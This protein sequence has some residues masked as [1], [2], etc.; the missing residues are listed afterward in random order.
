MDRGFGVIAFGLI[1]AALCSAQSNPARNEVAPGWV[2]ESG[3]D[4]PLGLVGG[5]L[6]H[7]ARGIH[8]PIA[9]DPQTEGGRWWPLHEGARGA[10]I[11]RRAPGGCVALT[12][13]TDL[14]ILSRKPLPFG[15]D[16]ESVRFFGTEPAWRESRFDLGCA[17]ESFCLSPCL[18]F[19]AFC[20]FEQSAIKIKNLDSGA[21][22]DLK[23]DFEGR[24]S[25]APD[26]TTLA[27]VSC[28]QGVAFFPDPAAGPSKNEVFLTLPPRDYGSVRFGEPRWEHANALNVRLRIGSGV[29]V[30]AVGTLHI[31]PRAFRGGPARIDLG[32]VLSKKSLA[33]V[34]FTPDSPKEQTAIEQH[35][36]TGIRFSAPIVP[37]ARSFSADSRSFSADSR[38]FSADSRS[39]SG[40][41]YLHQVYDTPDWFDG[42]WAC[43]PTSCVM[44]VQKWKRLPYWLCRC[45]YP[46]SH[47]S[48][49]GPLIAGQFENNGTNFNW[50]SYDASG[51]PARGA[52]G[53][54]CPGGSAYWSRMNDFMQW[55]GCTTY[56]DSSP[57]WS[58]L[59]AQ[60][61]AGR[62]AVLSTMLTSAGHIVLAIGYYS[63]HSVIIRDPYGDK[64]L[65][66]PNYTS[67]AVYDWPG[68]S[69]GNPSL[70][71]VSL[72]I[73]ASGSTG[74]LRAIIDD[75]TANVPITSFA[76]FGPSQY[77][78]ES[79]YYGTGSPGGGHAGTNGMLYTYSEPSGGWTNWA[80]WGLS[81]KYA[82][83]FKIEVFVPQNL[84]TTTGAR[85][86]HYHPSSGHTLLS[87]VNQN[88]YYDEW[89]TIAS[90]HSF[91]PG[92]N[93]IRLGDVTG[94]SSATMIGVDAIRLTRR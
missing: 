20:D 85:Y 53:Y 59:T 33:G 58:E 63:N 49:H 5:K 70:N 23:R 41:P 74:D 79:D 1:V 61:D 57:T 38:S 21:V 11:P 3:D 65:G 69:N 2:L 18:G 17:T 26:G 22:A 62:P 80:Q 43:G 12:A 44:A 52:Y 89:V 67:Q 40:V 55:A 73:G 51:R 27:V 86:Y 83:T 15:Y 4:L 36:L 37:Q 87:T 30:E 35:R 76:R 39:V 19:V 92:W 77:W 71:T 25:W 28:S 32:P 68:Y 60:I 13:G 50:V 56:Y 31:D 7:G 47:V 64:A 94:E 78:W 84:A 24:P 16:G 6:I 45:S 42:N 81:L 34:T 93:Y 14:V 48:Y 88:N 72:I 90:Y 8:L 82:G 9:I 29:A 54:I 75:S 46:T 10:A 66:Y 91:S